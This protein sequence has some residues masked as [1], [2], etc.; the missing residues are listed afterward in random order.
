[1][2]NDNIKKLEELLND[3]VLTQEEFESKKQKY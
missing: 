2:E 1:M 3:G